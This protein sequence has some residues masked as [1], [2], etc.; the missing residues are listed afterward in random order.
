MKEQERFP[1]GEAVPLTPQRMV[2]ADFQALMQMLMTQ[3]APT[4]NL[5]YQ[6]P[7]IGYYLG[8]APNGQRTTR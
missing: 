5:G 3:R 1:A 4:Q 7:N 8:G 6:D 2:D